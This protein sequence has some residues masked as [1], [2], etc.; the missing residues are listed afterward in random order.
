MTPP[1]KSAATE[2]PDMGSLARIGAQVRQRLEADVSAFRL[3]TEQVEIFAIANF[4]TPSECTRLMAII[5]AVAEPSRL[6]DNPYDSGFRTSYSGNMSREDPFVRMIER[7]IDDCLGMPPANGE[8]VQGQRYQPGQQFKPHQDY[9]HT[10]EAYW[11]DVRT[12]GG[13]RS[14]TAMAYLNS[15]EA[16]GATEFPRISLSI[17]PQAGAL[18][19]WNNMQ[20]DG[21]PN[22]E[23]LHAG[24]PVVRGTKYII[25]KWYRAKKWA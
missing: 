5:D 25:T 12:R 17:P 4:F 1:S 3:P 16:G 24:R 2:H 23:T 10:T 9:F 6:F 15:V 11:P 8:T 19:V 21:S 22:P 18:L 20:R 14:W 13:Q 7:K